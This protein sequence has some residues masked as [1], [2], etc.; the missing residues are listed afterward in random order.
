L[1]NKIN[2]EEYKILIIP[3]CK[4]ISV[5]NLQKIKDFFEG[6]GSIVFTTR[7]PSIAVEKGKNEEVVNLIRSIF[8]NNE[9]SQGIIYT[10][11]KGGKAL[12]ISKPTP[13]NLRE[14]L[15]EICSEFDVEYP[16]NE[17]IRYIHK[18]IKG[19]DV[20]YFANTGSSSVDFPVELRGNLKLQS[21][22]PHTGNIR[23]LETENNFNTKNQI[24]QTNVAL[25]LKAYQ[26]VFWI[27]RRI[28]Q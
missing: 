20:F 10:S 28:K 21:W 17:D 15:T 4:T 3:S 11:K 5:S 14:F 22:D 13:N 23:D 9:S 26:S 1:Q 24:N 6:G 2:W 25:N 19:Q 12:Y 7:L 18:V 16:V 8:P 27:G